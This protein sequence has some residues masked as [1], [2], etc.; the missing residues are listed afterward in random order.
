MHH[1]VGPELRG[2]VLDIGCGEGR[3]VPVLGDG[4]SWVGVD[5]SPSQ[6]AANPHRPIVLAN[7][8]ALPF[9]DGSFNET[10]HLWCLYHLD[11]PAGA[12]AEAHRVLSAGGRY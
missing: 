6:A 1:V 7:M 2:P 3:L 5:S 11:E 9:R 8:T 4:V 12:I 10:V